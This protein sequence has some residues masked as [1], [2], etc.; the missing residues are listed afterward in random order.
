M[1]TVPETVAP[2]LTGAGE[3][4]V[5]AGGVLADGLGRVAGPRGLAGPG[6]SPQPALMA[7]IATNVRTTC[8][9]TDGHKRGVMTAPLGQPPPLLLPGV[10]HVPRHGPLGPLSCPRTSRLAEELRRTSV[11]QPGAC[12]APGRTGASCANRVC[13]PARLLPSWRAPAA[14]GCALLAL[15]GSRE[16]LTQRVIPEGSW[17]A[18]GLGSKLEVGCVRRHRAGP[19]KRLPGHLEDPERRASMTRFGRAVSRPLARNMARG[20]EGPA[21]PSCRSMPRARQ[22]ELEGGGSGRG[23]GVSTP[24]RNLTVPPGE[25]LTVRRGPGRCARPGL[26]RAHPRSS[27]AR[28]WS[29]MFD[30]PS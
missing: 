30:V 22:S 8:G 9:R 27:F 29:C 23:P 2:P 16:P 1:D 5:V 28:V 26:V 13:L 24:V 6:E 12:A 14:G 18:S 15:G 19:V 20:H 21:G 17:G 11:G 7:T 3:G 10:G 25:T 4:D